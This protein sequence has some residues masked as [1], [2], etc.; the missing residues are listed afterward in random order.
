MVAM[1]E[2]PPKLLVREPVDATLL[3]LRGS[4]PDPPS[5]FCDQMFGFVAAVAE[6]LHHAANNLTLA[7]ERPLISLSGPSAKPATHLAARDSWTLC[8]HDP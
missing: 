3:A 4:Q 7:L 1:T 5:G 6:K 8:T 2:A